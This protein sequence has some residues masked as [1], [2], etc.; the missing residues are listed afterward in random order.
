M[1]ITFIHSA[2]QIDGTSISYD[3]PDGINRLVVLMTG[4][5]DDEENYY[6]GLTFDGVSF[7]GAVQSGWTADHRN[8]GVYYMLEEDLP[9]A[10]T[11]T[12]G[13]AGGA[14]VSHAGISVAT[15]GFVKQQA[16]EDTDTQQL[17]LERYPYVEL[18]TSLSSMVCMV[19]TVNNRDVPLLKN[20][21]TATIFL[22]NI[23]ND[24]TV[25]GNY[26]LGTSAGTNQWNVNLQSNAYNTITAGAAWVPA[27]AEENYPPNILC[28]QLGVNN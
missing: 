15:Y 14:S 4:V 7:T 13:L 11:Y 23:A 3:L 16:P 25:G 28:V 5:Q 2:V 21:F 26:L 24:A 18:T 27:T 9:V 22:D 8:S 20:E 10:G 6:S 19:S 1:A 17:A 12:I